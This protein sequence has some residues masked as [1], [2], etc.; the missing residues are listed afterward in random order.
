MTLLRGTVTGLK[1]PQLGVSWPGCYCPPQA[2][3]YSSWHSD[4]KICLFFHMFWAFWL[5]AR[6][7]CISSCSDLWV[8]GVPEAVQTGGLPPSPYPSRHLYMQVFFREHQRFSSLSSAARICMRKKVSAVWFWG[9]PQ[10][11]VTQSWGQ[12]SSVFSLFLRQG[13]M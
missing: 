8:R 13:L 10:A 12:L 11:S 9:L 5:Y 4:L 3:A 1:M 7:S 6:F 2:H